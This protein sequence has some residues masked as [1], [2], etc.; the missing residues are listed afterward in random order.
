MVEL[1]TK[2]EIQNI[3]I[4][5]TKYVIITEKEYTELLEKI[6]DLEDVIMI[7]E[8]KLDP[9]NQGSYTIDEVREIFHK[10]DNGKMTE[11]DIENL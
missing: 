9:E 6:E 3:T 7:K 2:T 8:A 11:N 10:R 5:N 1:Q 4:Q